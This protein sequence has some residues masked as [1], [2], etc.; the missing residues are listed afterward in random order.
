MTDKTTALSGDIFIS[1]GDDFLVAYLNREF[2]AHVKEP[3]R[4]MT[5]NP[6][7]D[8]STDVPSFGRKLST[9]VHVDGSFDPLTHDP[10][11]RRLA[12][13]LCKGLEKNPPD[14]LVY[15]SS[16]AVYGRERGTD[17]DETVS[18]L[19]ETPYATSKLEVERFLTEWSAAN[20][21]TLTILRPALIVG[22]GMGGELRR[23]VNDIYRG[24]YHHVEGNEARCSVVHASDVARAALT[25]ADTGGV[26]NLTDLADPT[27]HDL[28]EALAY[29]MGNKRIYTVTPRRAQM[30]ARIGSW[31]PFLWL[32][33]RRLG[34]LS[35]TLTFDGRKFATRYGFTPSAVTDYLRNHQYDENS[36]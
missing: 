9:V 6:A 16:A 25:A 17:I 4:V 20:G 21:V 23:M 11:D 24:R 30:W 34:Q 31:I 19:P 7:F 22:T 15:I 12:G 29:R 5:L 2:S 33:R 1:G 18:P 3:Y 10:V 26:Y 13:N 35:S 28:A 27:R 14:S 32:N 8:L 36:L